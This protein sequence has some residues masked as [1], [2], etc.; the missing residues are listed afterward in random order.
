VGTWA[1]NPKPKKKKKEKDRLQKKIN[2]RERKVPSND[3]DECEII[4]YIG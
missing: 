4:L 3:S 1:L 2:K